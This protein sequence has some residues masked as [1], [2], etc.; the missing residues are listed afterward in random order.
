MKVEVGDVVLLR[1]DGWW[2]GCLLTIEEVRSW[3]VIGAIVTHIGT[4]PLRVAAADIVAVYR[5]VVNEPGPGEPMTLF[6]EEDK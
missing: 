5:K 2:A 4:A 6:R 3:G 1:G